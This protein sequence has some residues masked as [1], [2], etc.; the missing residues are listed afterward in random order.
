MSALEISCYT[1]TDLNNQQLK[2]PGK[3]CARPSAMHISTINDERDAWTEKAPSR[4]LDFFPHIFPFFSLF[5]QFSC[6]E[7]LGFPP[8]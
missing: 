6:W 3:V 7:P 8:L 2:A 1:S 5:F 4:G